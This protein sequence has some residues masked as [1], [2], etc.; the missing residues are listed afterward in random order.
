MSLLEIDGISVRFGGLTAVDDARL[1]VDT[2][3]S[4]ESGRVPTP[5]FVTVAKVASVLSL[6]LDQLNAAASD[7]PPLRKRAGGRG[8]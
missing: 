8:R 2:I 5:S 3:R 4:L 1:S 6:S 7:P